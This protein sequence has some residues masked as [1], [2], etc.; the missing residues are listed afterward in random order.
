M[1]SGVV[2]I[3]R[4]PNP[5][6]SRCTFQP[7]LPPFNYR[8]S[9]S[10]RYRRW[11]SNAETV[12]SKRFGFNFRGKGGKDEEEEEE[13]KVDYDEVKRNKKRRW[14]SDES[15]MEENASDFFEEVI[16]NVWIF[17]VLTFFLSYLFLC[18][19]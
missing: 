16:N 12:R 4:H 3:F 11:D 15:V 13:D 6:R 10:T 17:K 2:F 1:E 18:F 19:Y 8:H 7:K 14:W 9:C 5:W